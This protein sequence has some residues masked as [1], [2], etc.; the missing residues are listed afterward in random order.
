MAVFLFEG[1]STQYEK[2]V[3]FAN[4]LDPDDVA[5]NGLPHLGL[6]HLACSH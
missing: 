5:H 1:L 4:S 3:D 6:L 2:I